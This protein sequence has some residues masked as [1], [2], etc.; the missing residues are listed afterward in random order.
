MNV[1][2][3]LEDKKYGKR[4]KSREEGAEGR[5]RG[6]LQLLSRRAKGKL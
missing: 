3:G 4:M 6:S 5:P 2:K 1:V